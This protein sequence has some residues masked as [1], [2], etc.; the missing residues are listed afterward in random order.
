MA[1][2]GNTIFNLISGLLAK[3]SDSDMPASLPRL[4]GFP[5]RGN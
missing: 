4:G 3:H 2:S 1:V 5:C